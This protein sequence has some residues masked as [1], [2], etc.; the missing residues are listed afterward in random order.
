MFLDEDREGEKDYARREQQ[1]EEHAGCDSLFPVA[2]SCSV[3]L[4][5]LVLSK[6]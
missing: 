3:S 5:H 4:F 6:L 2:R 1:Q